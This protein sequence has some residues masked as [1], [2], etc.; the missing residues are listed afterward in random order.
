MKL[1]IK[2]LSSK[3]STGHAVRMPVAIRV[4]ISLG[5]VKRM[6]LSRSPRQTHIMP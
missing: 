4:E 5:G 1:A 6:D 2:C 3:G